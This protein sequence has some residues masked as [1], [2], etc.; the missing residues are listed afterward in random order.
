MC[1]G[2]VLV[3]SSTLLSVPVSVNRLVPDNLE[4]DNYCELQSFVALPRLGSCYSFSDVAVDAAR[5]LADSNAFM[6]PDE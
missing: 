6:L 3:H 2:D 5:T 1:A 4:N